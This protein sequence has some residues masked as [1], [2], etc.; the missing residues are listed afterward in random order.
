MTNST[1]WIAAGAY[2]LYAAGILD[3]LYAAGVCFLIGIIWV[4]REAN[5]SSPD[6][7]GSRPKP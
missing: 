6:G 2:F 7:G 3:P 4:R 1:V 5:T